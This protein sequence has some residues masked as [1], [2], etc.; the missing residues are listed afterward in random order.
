VRNG[1]GLLEIATFSRYEVSGEGAGTWL[2][3]LVGTFL[4]E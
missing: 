2:D 3:R 4:S 1:V